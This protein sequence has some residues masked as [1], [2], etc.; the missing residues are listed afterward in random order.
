MTAVKRVKVNPGSVDEHAARE[1]YLYAT[2]DSDL[3]RQQITP[4]NKNL[5]T[6][7]ARGVYKTELAIKLAMYL[8]EN[9][10]KKYVREFGGG[11]WHD[12]FNVPTRREAAK[13][14]V[15]HFENEA[16]YGN[17]DSL[18]PAKYQKKNGATKAT[19]A[20]PSTYRLHNVERPHV[21]ADFPTKQAAID[22]VSEFQAQYPGEDVSLTR[23]TYTKQKGFGQF[24]I[25]RFKATKRNATANDFKQHQKLRLQELAALFQ[26]EANGQKRRVLE[27]DYTPRQKYRLG[28]L[29][30]LKIKD[31]G[32]TIPITVNGDEKGVE[33]YLA[34]DL[35]NNLWIVGK[36]SR[37]EGIKLPPKGQLKYL[38][39]LTQIDYVTAKRHIGGGKLIHFFHKLGE[40]T[41]EHPNLMVDDEG[42]PIIVGGGY[43]IW[44]IGIVN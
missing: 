2:N 39:E 38:G 24:F 7:K 35:R 19:A 21:T 42:F 16:Q 28:Y 36:D 37:I 40:V 41:G 4:I 9:A 32:K 18:L 20:N 10:A 29:K 11:N 14:F 12:Q 33:A 26:G 25:K 3:Y 31:R 8:M 44:D 1:L 17:Y 43:S 13:E 23:R 5:I 34:G 27:S 6:K 30:L 22:A 15:E